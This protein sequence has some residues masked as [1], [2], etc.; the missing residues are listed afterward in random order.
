M[1]QK[2]I[3]IIDLQKSFKFSGNR[4]SI[5]RN[6]NLSVHTGEFLAIMGPSGS[7]KSTLMNIIGL[8]DRPSSGSYQLLGH[9]A[10]NLLEE[11]RCQLRNQ[12]MGFVFQSFNL[13]P[14]FS[15]QRNVEI[16]M[17]YGGLAPV[18]R[19]RRARELLERVGLSHRLHH[20]PIELS[21]GERQRVGIARALANQPSVILADEPTGNLDQ[22]TGREILHLFRELLEEGKTILMVTHDLDVAKW[23]DRI[24]TIQDGS[25][26]APEESVVVIPK[27]ES[28]TSQ[29]QQR[30]HSL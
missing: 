2:I 26:V 29:E 25:I 3:D 4:L 27:I 9:E 11:E 22:R 28:R 19:K 8:M 5:L 18:E 6:I 21:G 13:L 24:V 10:G 1:V 14:R 30:L 15:A 17:L 16:P 7:G 20:R 23:A 12:K